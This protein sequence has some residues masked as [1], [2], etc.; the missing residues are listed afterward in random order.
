MTRVLDIPPFVR[1]NMILKGPT[2]RFAIHQFL[3][4]LTARDVE[5]SCNDTNKQNAYG[6]S[7]SVMVTLQNGSKLQHTRMWT[8]NCSY[9]CTLNG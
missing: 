8:I 6:R 4:I 7:V 3:V 2:N 9:K 1:Q 5:P